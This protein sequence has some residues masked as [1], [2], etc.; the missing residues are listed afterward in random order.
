MSEIQAKPIIRPWASKV[1]DQLRDWRT[2][3][4]WLSNLLIGDK[5][6]LF[7][8]LAYNER[9]TTGKNQTLRFRPETAEF[10]DMI[11]TP[12]G[13]ALTGAG[14]G[15]TMLGKHGLEM[16]A[17]QGLPQ[18]LRKW[19]QTEDLLKQFNPKDW[20]GQTELVQGAGG[21][22]IPHG[23]LRDA[24][25][26]VL[27]PTIQ[28]AR[29]YSNI[30]NLDR[31]GLQDAS[32]RGNPAEFPITDFFNDPIIN[33]AYPD[34]SKHT[35]RMNP[36]MEPGSG[37]Y[38]F[39]NR[40]INMGPMNSVQNAEKIFFHEG[41]HFMQQMEGFPLGTNPEYMFDQ[42]GK[43]VDLRQQLRKSNTALPLELKRHNPLLD[44]WEAA[45]YRRDLTAEQ[46]RKMQNNIAWH[47]YSRE[48]GEQLAE[49]GARTIRSMKPAHT[50]QTVD[51]REMYDVRRQINMLRNFG[52]D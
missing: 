51:P 10:L 5:P 13:K 26:E 20:K 42:L 38:D 8:R 1:A 44:Q 6:E 4:H 29:P 9:L 45:R 50:L 27:A 23:R 28:H 24:G 46:R 36:S 40:R 11:P 22:A 32:R 16:L 21:I 33:K 31:F 2:D 12:Q 52:I 49:S 15:I 39:R 48:A 35:V 37:S 47:M 25:G 41:N 18:R 34:F 30:M 7:D 3:D 17:E 43:M 14:V 19:Q